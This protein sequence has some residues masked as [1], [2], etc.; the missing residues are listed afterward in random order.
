MDRSLAPIY[1]ALFCSFTGEDWDTLSS[2]ELNRP[3]YYRNIRVQPG[4]L[5]WLNN[6]FNHSDNLF[7][8][9]DFE[10]YPL[11]KE[12]SII[13]L[14]IPMTEEILAVPRHDIDPASM[15]LPVFGFSAY[16]IPLMILELM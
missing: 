1:E 12:F 16:E 10:I 3:N 2:F 11:F 15:V 4:L 8:H 7:Q 9:N 14:W 13:F 5:Q 6:H